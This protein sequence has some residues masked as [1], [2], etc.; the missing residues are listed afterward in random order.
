MAPP[1]RPKATS[2]PACSRLRTSAW[3][4]VSCMAALH[5]W[6]G[7]EAGQTKNLPAVTA[8]EVSRE[9]GVG[10]ALHENK[11]EAQAIW[12]A[13]SAVDFRPTWPIVPELSRSSP[14]TA[15]AA[16]CSAP[17]PARSHEGNEVEL[18][19]LD[20]P[21]H[22]AL[23]DRL[24][25]SGDPVDALAAL[26][27][28]VHQQGVVHVDLEQVLD[29]EAVR[30]H[31]VHAL[32][33]HPAVGVL[34]REHAEVDLARLERAEHPLGGDQLGDVDLAEAVVPRVLQCRLLREGSS[35]PHHADSQATSL[36]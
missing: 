4:P 35:D 16:G 28:R 36:W 13:C 34:Q 11:Y 26:E 9:P 19:V 32:V 2:T 23:A 12:H 21:P 17:R 6:S 27:I 22:A 20:A 1:G 5:D 14:S 30:G 10:L 8:S 29:V 18:E 31:R 7:W 33:D 25:M 24:L 3:A 15:P